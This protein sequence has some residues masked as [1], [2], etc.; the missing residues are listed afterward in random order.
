MRLVENQIAR[1]ARFSK[2]AKEKGE[3]VS[4]KEKERRKRLPYRSFDL[5]LTLSVFSS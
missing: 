2:R 5:A 3:A 4:K 1:R